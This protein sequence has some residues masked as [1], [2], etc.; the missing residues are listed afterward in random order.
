MAQQLWLRLYSR[1][2]D[3]AKLSILAPSD[4]WYYV[5]LLCCKAQGIFDS[6]DPPSILKR[7]LC[8]KLHLTLKELDDLSARLQEVTLVT[9]L[10]Q[11]KGWNEKQYVTDSP[12]YNADKQ[13]KYR[14]RYHGVTSGVTT[15]LP[16]VTNQR[17][18]Q[19]QKQSKS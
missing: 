6:D 11:P 18:R 5:A 3:N 10:L 13:K 4:R 19:R 1:T 14:K 8:S 15:S 12:T 7:K 16:P 2:I 17:Q 9:E